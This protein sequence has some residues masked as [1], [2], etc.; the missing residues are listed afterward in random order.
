MFAEID[1]EIAVARGIEDGGWMTIVTERA[2]IEARAKVTERIRP[3]MIDGRR[4]HQVALP[5]HWGYGGGSRGDAAN[6]LIALTGDPN[7][8][9]EEAKAFTC[10]VR[11]GRRTRQTTEPLRAAHDALHISP[12]QD[13]PAEEPKLT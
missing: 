12:R 8:T 1:P 7:V 4:V 2:E 11:A 9:I 6:D 3:L 10:D 13:H 5:F